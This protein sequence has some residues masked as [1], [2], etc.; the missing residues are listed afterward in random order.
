MET[1]LSNEEKKILDD[2]KEILPKIPQDKKERL[3][4]GLEF[5]AAFTKQ[6]RKVI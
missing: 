2:L 5:L 3:L 6:Q 4:I 1:N